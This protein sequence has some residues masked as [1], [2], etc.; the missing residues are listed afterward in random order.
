MSNKESLYDKDNWLHGWTG[1][2]LPFDVAVLKALIDSHHEFSLNQTRIYLN[3][4]GYKLSNSV[5]KND[6]HDIMV[7]ALFEMAK[8][9]SS[10]KYREQGKIEAYLRTIIERKV[11]RFL[12]YKIKHDNHDNLEKLDLIDDTEDHKTRL[13]LRDFM[14][15]CEEDIRESN[16]PYAINNLD[17]L[18]KQKFQEK[19]LDELAETEETSIGGIKSRLRLARKMLQDCIENKKKFALDF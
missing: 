8:M 10:E 16:I 1:G 14:A 13:S 12:N 18:F 7:K 3:K 17:L 4:Y 19:S 11:I 2:D 9:M 15:D 6:E 5:K